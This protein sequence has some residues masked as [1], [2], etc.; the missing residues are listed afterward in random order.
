MIISNFG[1]NAAPWPK[2]TQKS[3]EKYMH[4]GGGFVSV[5]AA[6]NCFPEWLE[7]NRMIGLG[8]WG[9][10]KATLKIGKISA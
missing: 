1:Y 2:E 6:D 8:G 4:D 3:F 7:Y 9:G 5:H 10:R